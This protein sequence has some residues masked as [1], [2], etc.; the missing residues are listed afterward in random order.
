MLRN[1]KVICFCLSTLGIAIPVAAAKLNSFILLNVIIYCIIY[2]AYLLYFYVRRIALSNIS[3]D[4]RFE[5]AVDWTSLE[6]VYY[7]SQAIFDCINGK[8]GGKPILI[9]EEIPV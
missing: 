9:L 4:Y 7:K 1:S 2:L 8:S 6:L 5:W 3:P